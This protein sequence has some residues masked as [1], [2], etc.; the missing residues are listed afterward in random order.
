MIKYKGLGLL[1]ILCVVAKIQA[2]TVVSVLAVYSQAAVEKSFSGIDIRLQAFEDAANHIYEASEV[3][4]HLVITH[5]LLLDDLDDGYT[6]SE[7]GCMQN[8]DSYTALNDLRLNDGVFSD[9]GELRDASGADF[10]V[11]FR[12]ICDVG[13]I[14]YVKPDDE[15]Y[16]Y[17]RYSIVN[18]SN[19]YTTFAHEI[20]HNMGLTHSRRQSGEGQL[21]PYAVG[22]GV[23]ETQDAPGF[24]TM[25]AYASAF[26]GAQRLYQM[27]HPNHFYHGIPLGVDHTDLLHG[28]DSVKVVNT[29]KSI[30]SNYG[31]DSGVKACSES[32]GAIYDNSSVN[33][34]RSQSILNVNCSGLSMHDLSALNYYEKH[35]FESI[36]TLDL[37]NNLL[38]DLT[39]LSE[40]FFPNLA[41]VNLSD[42]LFIECQSLEDLFLSGV[43]ILGVDSCEFSELVQT[44]SDG[45]ALDNNG[46]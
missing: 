22:Y 18:I 43:Y 31:H 15:Y 11:L 45:Q 9:I 25:M 36:R 21:A 3:G 33:D 35:W 13:G 1:L 37:S 12:D 4:I 7:N 30:Y 20:G 34:G 32:L 29:Y 27:S 2:K 40:G 5:Q 19:S 10:V 44:D 46:R 38:S 16:D 41:V 26:E 14:A 39:F 17:A 42:N 23:D 8:Y 24:A 28:A 6:Q